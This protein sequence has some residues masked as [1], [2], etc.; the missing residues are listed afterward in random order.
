MRRGS[1]VDNTNLYE[2]SGESERRHHS[3]TVMRV[4]LNGHGESIIMK[5]KLENLRRLSRKQGIEGMVLDEV[6]DETTWRWKKRM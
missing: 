1:P 5:V 3:A 6:T 4:F 2:Y